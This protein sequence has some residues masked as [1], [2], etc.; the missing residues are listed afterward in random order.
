M[1]TIISY[2]RLNRCHTYC[3]V[4]SLSYELAKTA[5]LIM[6]I[7]VSNAEHNLIDFKPVIEINQPMFTPLDFNIADNNL[8]LQLYLSFFIYQ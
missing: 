1:F 8:I 2:Y 3:F 6:T 7:V 5:I 4:H